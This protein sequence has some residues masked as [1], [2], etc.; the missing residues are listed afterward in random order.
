MNQKILKIKAEV[1]KWKRFTRKGYAI[2]ASLG[3]EI[4]ISTL[5]V[6]TLSFAAPTT[7][8]AQTSMNTDEESVNID[9]LPELEV[10]L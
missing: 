7:A 4:V 6:V 9:T 1:I 8:Q 2:F 3:R 5:S 10:L